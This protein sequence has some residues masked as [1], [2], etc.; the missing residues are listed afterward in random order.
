[1]RKLMVAWVVAA[2]ALIGVSTSAGAS[3][4]VVQGCV[5]STFSGAAH[6]VRDLGAPPGALGDIVSGFAQSPDGQAG[7]GDGIQL[8]QAGQT[9]DEVAVNTCND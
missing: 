7:L 3:D 8:L 2:T 6:S 5:G 1:M 4:P 9:P